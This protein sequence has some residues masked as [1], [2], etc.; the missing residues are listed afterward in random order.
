MW[1][2]CGVKCRGTKGLTPN[3][4]TGIETEYNSSDY[5]GQRARKKKTCQ[6]EN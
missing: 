6:D 5:T 3:I 4:K 2:T 1:T